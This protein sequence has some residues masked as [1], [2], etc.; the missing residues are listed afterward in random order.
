MR[1]HLSFRDCTVKRN[2]DDYDLRLRFH[3]AVDWIEMALSKDRNSKV[4]VADTHEIADYNN[5]HPNAPLKIIEERII[6]VS[7]WLT[8]TERANE[9]LIPLYQKAELRLRENGLL[10]RIIAKWF[11]VQ[12]VRPPP[13]ES[14]PVVL[15]FDH[16]GVAFKICAGFI[17]L[18]LLTLIIEF[19]VSKLRY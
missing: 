19:I 11:N 9:F 1:F 4:L 13:L 15:T 17:V 6:K 7:E 14:D 5:K 12:D 10:D 2:L 16:V 18:S 3:D 8:G